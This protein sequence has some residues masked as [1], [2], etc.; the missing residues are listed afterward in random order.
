M[1]LLSEM[2]DQYAGAL[3]C[4]YCHTR[5][6]VG[7]YMHLLDCE[8]LHVLYCYGEEHSSEAWGDTPAECLKNWNA[9]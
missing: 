2:D 6:R 4:P 9:R 8:K 1:A 3:G 5:P 7:S